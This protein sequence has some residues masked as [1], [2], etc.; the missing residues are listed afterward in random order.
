MLDSIVWYDFFPCQEG[1]LAFK[2][3]NKAFYN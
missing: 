3:L 1:L 2:S